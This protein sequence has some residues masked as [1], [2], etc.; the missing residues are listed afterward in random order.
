MLIIVISD[1]RI[2]IICSNEDEEKSHIVSR[3]QPYFRTFSGIQPDESIMKYLKDHFIEDRTETNSTENSILASVVDKER[4]DFFYQYNYNPSNK[5][6]YYAH[7]LWLFF[8]HIH[9]HTLTIRSCVRVVTSERAGMGKSLY[10]HRLTED[11]MT[12]ICVGPHKV[13]IPILESIDQSEVSCFFEDYALNKRKSE[14]L[15]AFAECQGIVEWI[16]NLGGK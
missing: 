2:V 1:Y 16:R 15:V 3:L 9:T 11:L 13:I 12:K 4:L 7:L 10:I 6:N 5:I 8:W 14:C